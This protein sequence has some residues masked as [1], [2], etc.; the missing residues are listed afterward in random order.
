M[1]LLEVCVDT[2]EGVA[3]AVAGG[4]YRIELCSALELGGLTP[5]Y[6]F[7]TAAKKLISNTNTTIHV[8]VR[9]R[10]GDFVYTDAEVEQMQDDI[11]M[12]RDLGVSGVVLGASLPDGRLSE[13][14]LS[15]L[16][17]I[18][19]RFPIFGMSTT[20]HRAFDLV[21]DIGEAVDLA[22][23]LGFDRILTSGR[24][25]TA[26]E[27]LNDIQ[28]AVEAS[29]GRISIMPGSGV[30]LENVTAIL[31]KLPMI[32]EIHSSCSISV[33]N[34]VDNSLFTSI[35][36]ADS[37]MAV[38]GDKWDQLLAMFPQLDQTRL[39]AFLRQNIDKNAD[40]VVEY[41]LENIDDFPQAQATPPPRK[42]VRLSTLETTLNLTDDHD[43]PKRRN[44]FNAPVPHHPDISKAL[45][46]IVEFFAKEVAAKEPPELLS[47]DVL[48]FIEI[49]ANEFREI[50]KPGVRTL[51]EKSGNVMALVIACFFINN[52]LGHDK[53]FET[54]EKYFLEKQMT[55]RQLNEAKAVLTQTRWKRIMKVMAPLATVFDRFEA[56]LIEIGTPQSEL[57]KGIIWRDGLLTDLLKEKNPE[58]MLECLVCYAEVPAASVFFCKVLDRRDS[59]PC[60][61]TAQQDDEHPFCLDCI[62][63]QAKASIEDALLD[64]MGRG[65]KCMETKCNNPILYDQIKPY[66]SRKL[67][68]LLEERI[69]SQNLCTAELNNL[70]RCTNCG[71]AMEMEVPREV[72][73]VFKCLS[74]GH[75]YC[76]FCERDWK[77]HFGLSCKEAEAKD[78]E[79]A[80]HKL[81]IRLNEAIIRKCPRCN[82][83]FVKSEK[84]NKMICR[85]G[86]TM[87]YICRKTGIDYN[88]FCRHVRD[89]KYPGK[90][91]QCKE[92]HCLLWEDYTK[93]DENAK[94]EILKEAGNVQ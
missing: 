22:I 28:A 94:K 12:A 30:N 13:P 89:P 2:L 92:P 93:Y 40:L 35:K 21:P 85:C 84:C 20:L 75:S 52:R 47:I 17:S 68:V 74:C 33:I 79:D 1:V 11:V 29:A 5:S 64:K 26:L 14:V 82:L 65:L 80:R 23:Q 72:D 66:L 38:V 42:S 62:R 87:C 32:T 61:S 18:R 54:I 24:K 15:R 48:D 7:I 63:G 45:P 59:Q 67:R 83:A 44:R 81:E 55:R 76:R 86:L 70:E 25:K 6:G 49:I 10:A 71:I 41:I 88:H 34:S 53:N 36:P 90:C 3:A 78:K 43:Q 46:K 69:A 91:D 31:H 4:A 39:S 8:L 19:G 57:F 56:K 27:G 50:R 16:M 37:D 9:P 73:K 58:S 77:L 51:C 60:T